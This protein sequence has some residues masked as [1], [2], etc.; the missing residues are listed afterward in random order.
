LNRTRYVLSA[1]SMFRHIV[2]SHLLVGMTTEQGFGLPQI[3]SV[4]ISQSVSKERIQMFGF[5]PFCIGTRLAGWREN[6]SR[7]LDQVMRLGARCLPL[8]QGV[9]PASGRRVCGFSRLARATS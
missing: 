3:D 9:R 7:G 8:A 1:I 6:T 4:A 2:P 5:N